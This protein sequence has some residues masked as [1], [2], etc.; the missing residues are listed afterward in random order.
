MIP[1]TQLRSRRDPHAGPPTHEHRHGKAGASCSPAAVV[2]TS[3]PPSHDSRRL[4]VG[5]INH[6]Q[7]IAIPRTIPDVLPC[8]HPVTQPVTV[9]L[10]KSASRRYPPPWIVPL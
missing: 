5:L 2:P 4:V 6:L 10:P 3:A 1:V 8:R 9:T 7:R